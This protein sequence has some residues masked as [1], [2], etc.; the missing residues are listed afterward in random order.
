M[1]TK[2]SDRFSQLASKVD[3]KKK[4]SPKVAASVLVQKGKRNAKLA[5]NRQLPISTTSKTGK[6]GKNGVKGKVVLK[7]KRLGEF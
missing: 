2:L 4:I 7:G 5:A 6:G 1:A 3:T